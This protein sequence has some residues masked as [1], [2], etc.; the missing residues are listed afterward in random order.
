VEAERVRY[1]FYHPDARRWQELAAQRRQRW[2][3]GSEDVAIRHRRYR[4]EVLQRLLEKVLAQAASD[5]AGDIP[6]QDVL[7]IIEQARKEAEESLSR[8]RILFWTSS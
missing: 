5:P 4:L 8:A 6:V 3:A 1:Y 7:K 2:L